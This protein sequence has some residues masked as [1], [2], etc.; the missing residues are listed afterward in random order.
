M[1][2]LILLGLSECFRW[3]MYECIDK[4]KCKKS[5]MRPLNLQTKNIMDDLL[6]SSYIHW[7]LS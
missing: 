6:S 3:K 1:I 5:G 7:L 4:N 2:L